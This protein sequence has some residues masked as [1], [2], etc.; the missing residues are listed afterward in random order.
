[1]VLDC[2]QILIFKIVIHEVGEMTNSIKGLLLQH[3]S[4]AL[5]FQYSCKNLDMV[6][7]SCSL[8]VLKR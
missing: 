4:P 2:N 1:M 3:K 7:W 6:P 5:D 8:F